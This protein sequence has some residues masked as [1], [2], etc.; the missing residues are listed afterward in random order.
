MQAMIDGDFNDVFD[1]I[2]S[3]AQRDGRGNIAPQTIVLPE[4]AMI[5]KEK[6]VAEYDDNIIDI[7]FEELNKILD[8]TCESL[9]YRFDKIASQDASIAPFMY[10]NKTMIGYREDEGIVS[11][12][13][14]GT[15]AV[16]LLGMAECLQILI[17]TDHTTSD[18]R[19]LA[20][21]IIAFYENKCNEYKKKYSLNYGV[22][23][24]PAESLAGKSMEH[25]K[26]KWGQVK[27]VTDHDYFTNSVH[28]PVWKNMSAFE[29]IDIECNFTKHGVAGVI[30]YVELE[31][32]IQNNL[33][34]LE[35]IVNYAMDNDI[36][37]FAINVPIDECTECGW[38]Q[39]MDVCPVCGSNLI[40][41]LR[42]VTGYLSTD[43]PNSNK[44]KQAEYKDRVKHWKEI[45]V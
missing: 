21:S 2:F 19:N 9:K 40:R 39:E 37:Y 3:A 10:K 23:Y 43:I 31:S 32:S 33:N 22:Y 4:I 13:K 29:K 17:G 1:G 18:G 12:L 26:S 6:Y 41:K 8:D 30:T 25:F 35:A 45:S 14:N 38:M 36:P 24:T 5:A 11:A 20:K 16:G 42:R 34:A 27:D 44:W 7:F 28:V 15:L